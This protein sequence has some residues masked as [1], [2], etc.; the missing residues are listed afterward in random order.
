MRAIA[1]VGRM[2]RYFFHVHIGQSVSRDTMGLELPTLKDAISN[3]EKARI[4]IMLE[5]ALDEL[6]LE[7][8]DQSGKVVALVPAA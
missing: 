3:A 6:W 5:D 1:R 7:I 4:E 8:M 2:P